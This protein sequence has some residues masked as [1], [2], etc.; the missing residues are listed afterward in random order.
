MKNLFILI[1]ILY[2]HSTYLCIEKY[3]YGVESNPFYRNL[4][5][6]LGLYSVL[7]LNFLVSMALFM[8]I[9][10]YWRLKVIRVATYAFMIINSLIV[11]SNYLCMN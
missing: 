6:S 9:S 1:R 10:K 11:I 3:G 4:I 8:L 2:L 7:A 5:A